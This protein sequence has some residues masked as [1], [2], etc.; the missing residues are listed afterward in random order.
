MK[1]KY[2]ESRTH[3][4]DE[5]S[6]VNSMADAG[7]NIN[8]LLFIL[9]FIKQLLTEQAIVSGKQGLLETAQDRANRQK[10]TPLEEHSYNIKFFF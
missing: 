3:I 2:V 9:I 4:R 5:C 8:M 10:P 6:G 7:V 1:F